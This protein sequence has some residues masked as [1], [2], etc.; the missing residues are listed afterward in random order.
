MRARAVSVFGLGKLGAS[1]AAIFA[2]HGHEV[3]GC[4]P[5][6]ETVDLINQR[7]APLAEPHLDEWLKIAPELYATTDPAEAV[8]RSSI[9]FVVVPTPS[10]PN[11]QF[12]NRYVIEAVR[13]IGEALSGNDNW[14][15]VVIVSTVMPGST[16]GPIAGAL[17]ETSGREAGIDVGL[18]YNPALIALGSVIHDFTH[19]DLVIVGADDDVSARDVLRVIEPT[20][21]TEPVVNRLSTVDAEIT[22]LSI[23]VGLV[24][25]T[26]Y[27]N[28]I[29]AV[30]EALPG[31]DANRVLDAVGSDNRIGGR[32]LKVGGNAAGPCLPRDAFAFASLA[33]DLDVSVPLVKGIDRANR[34][35]VTHIVGRLC[36]EKRVA[37][38]GL[39]YKAGTPVTDESLG[40]AAWK[41]LEQW[42]VDVIVYD[43]AAEQ[44]RDA[45]TA[46]TAELAIEWADAILVATPWPEFAGLDY[47][48]KRVL[49]VWSIL[50]PEDNIERLGVSQR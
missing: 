24:M 37:I 48:G 21:E 4:D 34:D 19:P 47:L 31:A 22:K 45:K 20:I 26:A 11:G 43:P 49:D 36:D 8:R 50:P 29:G 39:S 5:M 25:K 17:Q 32:Y 3:T 46:G 13:C 30:C 10:D 12:S 23:N 40:I 6:D 15:T 35:Q 27:A 44:E 38:L 18:A 33:E 14:Y 16:R 28:T 41:M 9:A 7:T 1:L 2:A 42:G